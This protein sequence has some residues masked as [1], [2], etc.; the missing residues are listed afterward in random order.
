MED[1]EF[2][3]DWNNIQNEVFIE[4]ENKEPIHI[5]N[6]VYIE[7]KD[8]QQNNYNKS[9][10]NKKDDKIK[11]IDFDETKIVKECYMDKLTNEENKD[12]GFDLKLLKRDELYVNLIHFDKKM[13]NDENYKYFSKFKVNVVGG[14]H[15]MDDIE[16]FK[17]YLK[18]IEEKNIPFIVISSGSSGNEV[19][20]IC[21]KYSFV[22]EVIIFC[23][24]Y[25]YNKHYIDEYPGYVNKVFTTITSVYKYIKT[26]G[27][28]YKD[29][30]K[31]YKNS[32]HSIFNSEFIKMNKQL[33]QCPVISAYE[34]DNCYFLV[35]RAYAHFF[36]DINDPNS[37]AIFTSKYFDI[38]K[39]YIN[40]SQ[41][42]EKKK[43]IS[44]FE[45]LKDINDNDTFVEL[46]INKYTGESDFCYLFNRAMRNFDEGLMSLAYYMGPF[47]FGLNKYV[48]E[49]PYCRFTTDMTLYRN[50]ECSKLDFYLYQINLDHIICFPS[51]TST[52]TVLGRF[53]PTKRAKKIN[54]IG[55]SEDDFVK[56]TMIFK[57]K[58]KDGNISPGIIIKD[59]K[60]KNCDACISACPSENEVILFPFTFVRITKIEKVPYE[61]E[62]KNENENQNEKK[63]KYK[64]ILNLDIINRDKYIEY[65]LKDNVEKRK[66]FSDLD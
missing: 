66:R 58:H 50:I 49:T 38:I 10:S 65:D 19:I 36:G 39:N 18:A 25:T 64:F 23:G 45:L 46:A 59:Y 8:K 13:R 43:L 42:E 17:K 37:K 22:K 15:A 7:G 52:S 56:V 29:G 24:N 27:E 33:E 32:N 41:F 11:K 54:N 55:L 28:K 60:R 62:K 9:Q 1:N 16:I 40:N 47:L 21:K 2:E 26:F 44:K 35:H 4:G 14:F 48:K 53:H 61:E 57:Y 31:K 12:I 51:I 34:Y 20:P 5:Q 63:Q 30:I 3:I 6:E